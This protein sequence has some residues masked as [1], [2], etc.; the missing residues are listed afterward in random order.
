[1]LTD[2]SILNLKNGESLMV[3]VDD[4][5]FIKKPSSNEDPQPAVLAYA[6]DEQVAMI[7]PE[8]LHGWA[9][10]WTKLTSKYEPME[11]YPINVV[12]TNLN[13]KFCANIL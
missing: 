3:K 10:M 7:L 2:K 4:I 5:V 1:M 9:L 8:R 12:F 6:D 13:G 11:V